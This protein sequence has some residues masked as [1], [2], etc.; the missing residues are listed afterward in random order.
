LAGGAS[1]TA[2]YG[3]LPNGLLSSLSTD[4]GGSGEVT[5]ETWA[6]VT[7]TR[8]NSHLFDF[9]S[10][11][12]GELTTPGGG[13]A[14]VDSFTHYATLGNSTPCAAS[15]CVIPT[16]PPTARTPSTSRPRPSTRSRTSFV[17]WKESSG[18]VRI[19]E[20]GITVAA[21]NTSQRFSRINDVNNWLGRGNN[22]ADQNAQ[23]EFDE[24]R[25]YPR[26]LSSGEVLAIIKPVRAC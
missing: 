14:V 11:T 12:G 7:G 9:G 20:N 17:T 22:T 26:V 19:F 18:D 2:A 4:N 1:S 24:F 21:F 8:T 15:K 3:D 13:G 23:V 10:T 25:L 16:T 6:R 5:F